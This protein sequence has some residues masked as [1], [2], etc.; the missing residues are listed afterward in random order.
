MVLSNLWFLVKLEEAAMS[1]FK[2]WEELRLWT[3]PSEE[4]GVPVLKVSLRN[5]SLSLLEKENNPS[6]W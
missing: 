6:D 4:G 2:C 1:L 5:Q 3:L